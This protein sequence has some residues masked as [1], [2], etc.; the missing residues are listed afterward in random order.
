MESVLFIFGCPSWQSWVHPFIEK[1]NG[2][3]DSIYDN[4]LSETAVSRLL[5]TVA[6]HPAEIVIL[7]SHHDTLM[8]DA[9]LGEQVSQLP[10]KKCIFQPR[11]V[12]RLAFDKRKMNRYAAQ[13]VELESIEE[14]ALKD[15]EAQ[16][17]SCHGSYVAKKVDLTEGQAFSLLK[18]R[19]DVDDF[20]QAI[21]S[22]R[23]H[24]IFQ[25]FVRGVEF[26]VNAVAVGDKVC[27]FHPISKSLNSSDAWQHPCR[28]TRKC[29]DDEVSQSINDRLVSITRDYV[30][31]TGA[32]A[33]IEIEFILDD[34]DDIWF[35][36][37]NPRLS[38]TTRMVS[39]VSDVDV[40]EALL[41]LARGPNDTC[42]QVVETTAFSEEFPLPVGV[43]KRALVGAFAYP[44]FS[45]SSRATVTAH[46]RE[47]LC[48]NVESVR[49]FIY[50]QRQKVHC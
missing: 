7:L 2:S 8:R 34:Q 11:E 29:P 25:K 48:T 5:Q 12:A 41:H 26:S 19:R 32:Q 24:Y 15:V 47:Q 10:G 4:D 9:D 27:V 49:K 50:G 18:S 20:R 39:M 33:L 45:F 30:A 23:D 44:Y 6:V 31:L 16:L 36:E 46:S 13:I 17:D 21:D 1:L 28:R 40:F 14:L 3:V 38:A 42:V 37:I 35:L 22:D 43:D